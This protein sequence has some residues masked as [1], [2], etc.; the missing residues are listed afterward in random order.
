MEARSVLDAIDTSME[1]L[2]AARELL[3]ENPAPLMTVEDIAAY[4]RCSS[5]HVRNVLT[6]NYFH[7]KVL[8][9]GGSIRLRREDVLAF[10]VDEEA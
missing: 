7:G 10:G 5:Q 9:I 1:A 2:K 4:W 3:A 6:T 8:R